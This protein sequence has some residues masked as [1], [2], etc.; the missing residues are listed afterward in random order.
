MSLTHPVT[1]APYKDSPPLLGEG[2]VT[3]CHSP[4]RTCRVQTAEDMLTYIRSQGRVGV[5]VEVSA[6]GVQRESVPLVIGKPTGRHD[7]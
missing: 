3:G 6:A 2:S 4:P 5:Q 7:V 1:F